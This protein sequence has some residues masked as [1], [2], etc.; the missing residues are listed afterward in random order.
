MDFLWWLDAPFWEQMY[1]V[2]MIAGIT[3]FI[4][5]LF[6]ILDGWNIK[7][8]KAIKIAKESYHA[9]IVKQRELLKKRS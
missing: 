2:T 7:L 1:A 4:V 6:K 8:R 9:E 5:E 3:F